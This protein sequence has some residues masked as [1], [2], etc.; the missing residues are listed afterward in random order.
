MACSCRPTL[1]GAET[2]H[3]S[4]QPDRAQAA[5][6]TAANTA[7][8]PFT[9]SPSS[10][11][12]STSIRGV[13][14]A[15]STPNERIVRSCGSPSLVDRHPLRRDPA[16]RHVG[17]ADAVA[18]QHHRV[19]RRRRSAP[20]RGSCRRRRSWPRP[21][22]AV[23]GV[24]SSTG[25]R[26]ARRAAPPPPPTRHRAAPPT[27]AGPAT[28]TSTTSSPG[29]PNGSHRRCPSVRTTCTTPVPSARTPAASG[30]RFGPKRTTSSAC[31]EHADRLDRARRP[32]GAPPRRARRSPCRRTRRRCR[33]SSSARHRARTTTRRVRGR[34]ARP[35]WSAA[36]AP[37]RRPAPRSASAAAPWCGALH[38]AAR[39]GPRRASRRPPTP[40]RRSA[41]R[42][43]RRRERCRRRSRPAPSA[44]CGPTDWA[45]PPSIAARRSLAPSGPVDPRPGAT[46]DRS[47]RSTIG[48]QPVHRHR[49]ASIAWRT[50]SASRRSGASA[51]TA[52]DDPGRAEA[53]LA[54][55]VSA[56]AAAHAP[57]SGSPSTVVTDRPATR[58]TGVTHD[59]RGW[60]STQTVQ[61]PH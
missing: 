33:A 38:L 57:A 61:Q 37:S 36:S 7:S 34:R 3:A 9:G 25:R 51:A 15:R 41:A 59:T 17:G 52:H 12:I 23:R 58:A 10:G 44:T 6:A 24:P 1:T 11:S 22:G 45:T 26:R 54:A 20:G 48:C 40:R 42:P 50:P 32:A 2:G 53:A 14:T 27:S 29:R 55:P 19:E 35:T 8:L 60:P 4:A 5:V 21:H 39:T 13:S 28:S 16:E 18:A 46:G 49:W 56:N 31:G 47:N 30:G 43:A